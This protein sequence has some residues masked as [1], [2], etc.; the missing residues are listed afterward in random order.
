MNNDALTVETVVFNHLLHDLVVVRKRI[1]SNDPKLHSARL[2][3]KCQ[4]TPPG[5]ENVVLKVKPAYYAVQNVVSVF[6]DSLKWIPEYP[7]VVECS[8]PVAVFG[9][10]DVNS[11]Q[12]VCVFWDKSDVPSDQNETVGATLEISGGS[13]P[14][15]V[16]ADTI[17]GGVHAI[18]ETKMQ[19]QVGK[20]P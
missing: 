1:S 17:T 16:W 19:I 5:N 2:T 13:F 10:R 6:N 4:F 12:Q 20:I 7:C 14:D 8:K 11:G 9:H 18:P 15:P 3:F